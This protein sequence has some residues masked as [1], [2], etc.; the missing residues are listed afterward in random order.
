[1]EM[2]RFSVGMIILEILAGSDLV[3]AATN[4]EL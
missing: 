2:D 1:M 3:L 4:E